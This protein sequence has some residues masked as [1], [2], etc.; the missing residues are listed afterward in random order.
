MARATPRRMTVPPSQ[1]DL[2]AMLSSQGQHT[3]QQQP[4]SAQRGQYSVSNSGQMDLSLE[5]PSD[6]THASSFSDCGI[7]VAEGGDVLNRHGLKISS[8]SSWK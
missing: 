6:K 7:E 2:K 5:G 8:R 3:S 4:S 1:P